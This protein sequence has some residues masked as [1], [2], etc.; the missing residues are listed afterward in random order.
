MTSTSEDQATPMV[1]IRSM[2]LGFESLIGHQIG[3]RKEQIV[4]AEYL[5][6]VMAMANERFVE[7]TKRI[8]RFRAAL[9]RVAAAPVAKKNPQG[10]DWEDAAARRERKRAEGLQRK[11]VKQ[12]EKNGNSVPNDDELAIAKSLSGF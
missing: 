4:T 8:E 6:T 5:H 2:G 12:S 10:E 11:A 3:D 1:G 7:N 9:R